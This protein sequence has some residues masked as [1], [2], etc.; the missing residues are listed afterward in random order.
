MPVQL[1]VNGTAYQYPI[2]GEDPGWGEDGT[3]WAQAV[4]DVLNTLLG[5]GDIL[6]TSFNI[7]NNVGVAT[8][9]N[10]LFFDPGTVRAA[11]IDYSVYRT[12]T[13][14]PSG[15]SETGTIYLIYD[16]SASAGNKWQLS[17]RTT[18]NSGVTFSILDSGQITYTSTDIGSVGYSG[19]IKFRA[20]TLGV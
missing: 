16:D 19:I 17:Q 11:N 2:P 4:T 18:G 20:K 3:D 10:G 8:N 9:V 5:A 1:I 15:F 6:Q 14:N 12:S 7:N 13:A